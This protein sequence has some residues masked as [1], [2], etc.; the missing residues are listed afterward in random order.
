MR[1]NVHLLSMGEMMTV[2]EEALMPF[3]EVHS[4]NQRSIDDIIACHGSQIQAIATRGR[5]RQ[6]LDAALI[7]GLPKLETIASFAVG[8]DSID[9]E[10]AR[11]RG[12]VVTN[13]PDVLNDEV[14][15]YTV[16]L[17]LAT[18]R[19]I[20][21]GDRFV[22]SGQW[23]QGQF[24]L[25]HSLRDRKIGFAGMGRIAS[26]TA[27]RLKAFRVPIAYSCRTPRPHLEFQFYPN[28]RD[29]AEAVD[30]LIVLLPG[31]AATDKVIDA[32][33]LAALGPRGILI[34][35][36]RGSVVDQDA[37]IHA[38]KSGVIASAGLDVF[39]DEP[40]VPQELREL[41]NVVLMPHTASGTAYT[42]GL[43]IDLAVRNLKSWFAGQGPITAV[44][45]TPWSPRHQEIL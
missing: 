27:E 13:T 26:A 12:V 44:P 1:I 20:P 29:L 17:L 37:V 42:R 41:D 2:A 23:S 7:R 24:P 38:L 14:A 30:V 33:V 28:V 43:M 16:G 45:E 36:A 4:T 3:F 18:L 11:Q 31:G 21:Q 15:D 32:E 22:R 40:W 35:V 19:R 34:N 8:Y 25:T 9:V 5:G 10:A 39:A 6:Q